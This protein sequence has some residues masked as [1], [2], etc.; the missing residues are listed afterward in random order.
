MPRGV[1]DDAASCI[2]EVDVDQTR[3]LSTGINNLFANFGRTTSYSLRSAV[4]RCQHSSRSAFTDAPSAAS[5]SQAASKAGRAKEQGSSAL[6]SAIRLS[7][8]SAAMRRNALTPVV[9]H[10]PAEDKPLAS[11][12][13]MQNEAASR[14]VAAAASYVRPLWTVGTNANTG[15]PRMGL[16]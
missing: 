11:R 9:W 4:N 15:A 6:T 3:M 16:N 10:N 14:I 12:A 5:R 8:S 1:A 2:S 7:A 13:D